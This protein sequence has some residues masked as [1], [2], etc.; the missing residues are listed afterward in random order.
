MYQVGRDKK[1][2]LVTDFG[3]YNV[4]KFAIVLEIYNGEATIVKHGE[5]SSVKLYF[6]YVNKANELVKEKDLVAD[7]YFLEFT[8]DISLEL[9]VLM[10]NYMIEHSLNKLTLGLAKA[11]QSG[12]AVK[13]DSAIDSFKAL[14]N[15]N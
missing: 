11:I 9:Q 13:I 3:S 1:I 7:L 8:T 2:H 14:M 6:D 5:A 10:V 15:N 12:E 4:D